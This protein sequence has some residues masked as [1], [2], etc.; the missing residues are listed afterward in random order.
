M[1]GSL[2][3]ISI[4]ESSMTTWRRW[5]GG[6]KCSFLSTFRVKNVHVD[7]GRWSIKGKNAVHVV[8]D[9]LIDG[10]IS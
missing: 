2:M 4:G 10:Q 8:M 9:F 5:V 6:P 3:S 1:Y 7:V